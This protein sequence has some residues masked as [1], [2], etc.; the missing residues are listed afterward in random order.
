MYFW[1]AV[2][3]NEQLDQIKNFSKKLAKKFSLDKTAFLL[4]MHV[5]L[6]ISFFIDNDKQ[7]EML[8]FLTDY[9]KKQKPFEIAPLQIESCNDIIWIKMQQNQ[10]LE[11]LHR[12]L[13]ELLLK[14]YGVSQH[15]FDL[16]F[17]FHST[18]FINLTNEQK[19]IALK[20]LKPTDLPK[21]IY[22]DSFLIGT[23]ASGKAGTYSVLQIVKAF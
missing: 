4:P 7:N 5:S 6:K 11:R 16:N 22:A 18:L 2:N 20:R 3:L 21:T 14:N 19:E 10:T 1:V 17:T 9:F 13:D 12:E 23:S 15:E 8:C